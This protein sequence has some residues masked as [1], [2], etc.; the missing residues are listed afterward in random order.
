MYLYYAKDYIRGLMAETHVPFHSIRSTKTLLAHIAFV[1][2]LARVNKLVALQMVRLTKT[3]LAHVTLIRSLVRVRTHVLFQITRI[4]K[5]F[6]AK[7]TLVRFLFRVNTHVPFQS[8]GL[9]KTL[10]ANITFV[11]FLVRVSTHASGQTGWISKHLVAH[12]ALVPYLSL[13]SFPNSYLFFSFFYSLFFVFFLYLKIIRLETNLLIRNP[14]TQHQRFF[15]FS[16]HLQ[17]RPRVHRAFRMWT[18]SSH[19]IILIRIRDFRGEEEVD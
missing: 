7:I 12:V 6:I 13:R 11:R 9:T 4:T 19:S 16:R 17:N 5:N 3:L 2:F 18:L 15:F 10:P 14:Q 1:R 8:T